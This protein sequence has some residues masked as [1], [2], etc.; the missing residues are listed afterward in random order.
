M[1]EEE[2]KAKT[3]RFMDEVFN[4]GNMAVINELL[5]PNLVEHNPFPGYP[6][7]LEG[8]KQGVAA[9]RK[10]FPDLHITV[11]DLIAEGDK[12]VIRSTMS[13]THKGDFMGTPATGKQVKVAGID[14]VRI[15]G[16]KA[17]EH[18]GITQ[19]LEMMQQLG[20]VPKM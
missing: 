1:S 2:N 20:L 9:F 13:G 4:K 15:V 3:R 12:V 16:G 14:I 19:D 6:P 8:F 18:W 7:G 17:V 10:G 5:A 11:D